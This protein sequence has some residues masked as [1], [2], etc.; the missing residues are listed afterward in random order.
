[1]RIAVLADIHG[2][3]PA[4]RA[5]LA[6]VDRDGSSAAALHAAACPSASSD[7]GRPLARRSR[8]GHGVPGAQRGPRLTGTRGIDLGEV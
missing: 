4:L 2:N 1:V 3:L 7:A 5:V 8:L 6:D